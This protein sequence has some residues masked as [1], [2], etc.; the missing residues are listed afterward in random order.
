MRKPAVERV[1][2]LVAPA[3]VLDGGVI[4]G[5]LTSRTVAEDGGD[6]VVGMYAAVDEI[7]V[8]AY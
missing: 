3:V 6:V 5:R 2:E 4:A 1:L 8:A 7:V